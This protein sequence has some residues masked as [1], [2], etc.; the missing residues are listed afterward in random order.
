MKCKHI[1]NH[2]TALSKVLKKR[3]TYRAI[4]EEWVKPRSDKESGGQQY[5]GA[6]GGERGLSERAPPPLQ[7]QEVGRA[8]F[9][10]LRVSRSHG[11]ELALLFLLLVCSGKILATKYFATV[12]LKQE[13]FQEEPWMK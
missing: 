1:L 9:H 7:E 11:M 3:T 10:H 4:S 13:Q 2:R 6:R 8:F 12:N 5:T